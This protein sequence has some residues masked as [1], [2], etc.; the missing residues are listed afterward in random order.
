MH[1]FIHYLLH[2]GY[3]LEE[4]QE[5][6]VYLDEKILG[7]PWN[8]FPKKPQPQQGLPKTGPSSRL[9]NRVL[10]PAGGTS[11]SRVNIK[12]TTM[13]DPY[14]S[15]LQPQAPKPQFG[16]G[17]VKPSKPGGVNITPRYSDAGIKA[18]NA[19]NKVKPQV[20]NTLS[21]VARVASTV[22]SL[23][24]LTPAGVAAA[25]MEPRPTADGTLDAARKRGDLN[26]KPQGVGTLPRVAAPYTPPRPPADKKAAPKL[27]KAQSFDKAFKAARTSGKKGFVWN[28]KTYTTKLRGESVMYNE[29][30]LVIECLVESGLVSSYEDATKFY[31]GMSDQWIDAL[32]EKMTT[33][34]QFKPHPTSGSTGI[35]KPPAPPTLPSPKEKP[36]G[37]KTKPGA[38][39]NS[40]DVE[41][42]LIDERRREE[43]GKPRKD[44]GNTDLAYRTVKKMIR[45]MEGTPQGQR[46][47]EPGK[48]P[49]VAGEYGAPR[50]PAQKLAMR[51]A[52]AKRSQEM[53]S[54]RFD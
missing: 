35:N 46:K 21:N 26:K 34:T 18:R 44:I 24:K 39:Y 28:N 33:Q 50:S 7:N 30:D 53:Q 25:V 48:K 1:E 49:P 41:G 32:V 19:L 45:K 16:P 43:K 23:R 31:T 29:Y 54:S 51:R 38:I 10:P 13:K 52:A 4:A 11:G 36:Q 3:S 42:E 5:F 47:K 9:P 12:S 17:A 40:Y 27:T 15:R 22:A 14:P 6:V 2:E 20:S 8:W 37:K